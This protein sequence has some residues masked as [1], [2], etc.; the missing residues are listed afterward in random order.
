MPWRSLVGVIRLRADHLDGSVGD[1]LFEQTAKLTRR[2]YR[3][4]IDASE[5]QSADGHGL[6]CL[7][8]IAERLDETAVA[9]VGGAPA[10]AVLLRSI[11]GETLPPRYA[12]LER[13][14]AAFELVEALRPGTG[15]GTPL[16]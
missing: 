16:R 9:L 14:L 10:F 5:V 4:V 2:G 13:A 7:T 8:R 3:T 15:G 12:S 1:L 6:M 11:P